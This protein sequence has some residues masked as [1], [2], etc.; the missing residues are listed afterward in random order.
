MTETP[1]L[2]LA[3]LERLANAV[4][5][6]GP[7]RAD[8]YANEFSETFFVRP[9]G[10]QVDPSHRVK[11]SIGT[12]LADEFEG[13]PSRRTGPSQRAAEFIA[14]CS[15]ENITTL[16]AA[17]KERDE[18]RAKLAAREDQLAAARIE[19]AEQAIRLTAK[20]P[21]EYYDRWAFVE[22]RISALTTDTTDAGER[23]A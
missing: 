21:D 7:W 8:Y 4:D 16:I 22:P 2:D 13:G 23:E 11:M 5:H 6:Q 19:G 15:P 14:M 9:V 3:E 1:T 18:L 12:T 10:L 17:A 20:T